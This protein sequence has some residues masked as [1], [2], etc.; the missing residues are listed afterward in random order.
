MIKNEISNEEAL[1]YLEEVISM[2]L[3]TE[4]EEDVYYDIKSR[5]KCKRS[6]LEKVK[7]RMHEWYGEK[8]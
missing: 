1:F 3:A 2:N 4:V 8:F 7:K 6:E 5:G